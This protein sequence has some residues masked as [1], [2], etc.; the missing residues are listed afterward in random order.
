MVK[1]TATIYSCPS[2]CSERLLFLPV[3]PPHRSVAEH[4]LW[5]DG[6]HQHTHR[7]FHQWEPKTSQSLCFSPGWVV[8]QIASAVRGHNH[9]H[10]AM[11]VE[12]KGSSI[13]TLDQHV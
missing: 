11:A 2:L 4:V 5:G 8:A 1:A 9:M 13:T 3:T 10:V 7:C 6:R 12:K